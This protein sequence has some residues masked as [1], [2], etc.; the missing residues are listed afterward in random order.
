MTLVAGARLGPYEILGPIGAG[1]MG[2]VYRARDTRLDRAVAIKVLPAHLSNDPELRLRFEREARA[3]SSLQH[4]NICTLHDV[5]REGD[6]DFLVM[7]F[8]EGETLAHRLEKGPLPPEQTL[9]FGIQI[10]EALDKAHRQGIVHRDL[11]PGNVML[12]R[13][14]VK[15]LDFGLAKAV[16]GVVGPAGPRAMSMMATEAARSQPLTSEGMLLGTFQYMAPEQLEGKEADARSDLFAFGSVLYEMATGHPAFEGK[17]RASLIGAIMSQQPAPMSAAQPLTPPALERVVRACLEKDPDERIQTAHDVRLQLQWILDGGSQMGVPAPVLA[18]R[19]GRE[20]LAWM[21]A[22][23]GVG[24]A[25]ALALPRLLEHHVT[26]GAVRFTLN[27]PRALVD[28]GSPRISPDGRY[29]VMDG[30]DTSGTTQLWL[31]PLDALEAQPLPG[32]VGASRGFWSPDSRWIGFIAGGK[33]KKVRVEGGAPQLI[34][35]ARSGSDGSWSKDGIIVFDGAGSDPL[36]MVSADGG[37]VTEL[38]PR[39]SSTIGWPEFLPDGRHLLYQHIL[40][41]GSEIWVCDLRTKRATRVGPGG[42]RVEYAPP[43]WLVYERDRTLFA[44]RFDATRL[45][46]LGDAMPLVE[47]VGTG[48]NGLAHFSISD[49]GQLVYS[50]GAFGGTQLVWV[51]RAGHELS[52]VGPPGILSQPALSPDGSR[53]AVTYREEQSGNRDI[54]ILDPARGTRTRFTFDPTNDNLAQW[55]P[56]GTRLVFASNPSNASFE[57]FEKAAS[58]VGAA[59]RVLTGAGSP[60]RIPTDWSRDGRYVLGQSAAAGV[61]ADVFAVDMTGERKAVPVVVTPASEELPRL[62]PDGRWLAYQSDE[63]GRYEIYVVSFP[64]VAGKWQ[65]SASGGTEPA[66]SGDGRELYFLAADSRMM[67]APVRTEP[68]FEPG[69][70]SMLFLTHFPAYGYYHFVPARDGKRFLVLQVE[71]SAVA[72][73]PVVVMNWDAGLS[74]H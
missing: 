16:E 10:A 28:T 5:G 26:P 54:W 35:D 49:H 73:P 72:V 45:K 52:R 3:I 48:P 41:S 21:L 31:R 37:P 71:Q 42:S 36:R 32:T 43:G 11:K 55:S 6:T 1:G 69:T 14:G 46:L 22:A 59:S 51:D 74:R 67:A 9:R 34:A 38:T 60:A 25:L 56:D 17:S 7:E 4:P 19:R 63:S 39:D 24:A 66:W 15:L 30:V 23:L 47:Q 8:L 53:V 27:P 40:A 18:R 2:E 61:P 12:T 58:G 64:D 57:L 68:T 44:Q 70:P 20:R 29:V 65:V 13:T 33:I 62:S 50:T